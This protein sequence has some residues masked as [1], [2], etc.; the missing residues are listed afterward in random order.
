MWDLWEIPKAWR[1]SLSQIMINSESI[2]PTVLPFPVPGTPR[3]RKMAPGGIRGLW[4]PSFSFWNTHTSQS[5]PCFP[6]GSCPHIMNISNRQRERLVLTVP[7]DLFEAHGSVLAAQTCFSVYYLT[8]NHAWW[9]V[10]CMH[11]CI[12]SKLFKIYWKLGE[13][14]I[15]HCYCCL[16]DFFIKEFQIS[17]IVE[18]KTRPP[19]IKDLDWSFDAKCSHAMLY[20]DHKCTFPVTNMS[21]NTVITNTV[22]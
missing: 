10:L 15:R 12:F 16:V 2:R 17:W 9:H 18:F 11:A 7:K 6:I 13:L 3:L 4:P 8:H 5:V 22:C 19:M 1:C 20:N 21:K 14:A